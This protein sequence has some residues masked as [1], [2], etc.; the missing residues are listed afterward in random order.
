VVFK[1]LQKLVVHSQQQQKENTT[2]QLS[3][4]KHQRIHKANP[5]HIVIVGK[6]KLLNIA[7]VEMQRS[8][9]LSVIECNK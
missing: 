6:S 1:D 3:K 7:S 2:V 4:N 8:G 5:Q 9:K